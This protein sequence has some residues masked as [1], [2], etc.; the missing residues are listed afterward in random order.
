MLS[1]INKILDAIAYMVREYKRK[2]VRDAKAKTRNNVS[3]ND[4]KSELSDIRDLL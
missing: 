1:L 3:N 2:K 4:S